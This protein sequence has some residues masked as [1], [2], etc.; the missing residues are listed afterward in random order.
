VSLPP[1]SW[2]EYVAF[3]RRYGW[4][5]GAAAVRDFWARYG[6]ALDAP[7]C[8]AFARI[9]EMRGGL[10]DAELSA[11]SDEDLLGVYDIGPVRLAKLRALV[12]YRS[13][14][15]WPA[16]VGEGVPYAAE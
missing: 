6:D 12:P 1:R 5:A 15:T 3:S 7:T 8:R 11:A 4:A 10:S 13:V 14:V 2:D 9:A 16:W